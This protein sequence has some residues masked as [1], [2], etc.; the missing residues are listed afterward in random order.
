MLELS[1]TK[2]KGVCALSELL[3]LEFDGLPPTINKMYRN[4]GSRR[5]KRQE[6]QY[7]QEDI[8]GL[9]SEHWNRRPYFGRVRINIEFI[10]KDKRN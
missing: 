7:W 9:L 1:I 3:S 5:Y 10:T 4:S 6:V 8:A 2:M